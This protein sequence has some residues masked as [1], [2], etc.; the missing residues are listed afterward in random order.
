MFKPQPKID[1]QN[2]KD[3]TL[4]SQLPY[5]ISRSHIHNHFGPFFRSKN[6]SSVFVT[7]NLH[8]QLIL[9]LHAAVKEELRLAVSFGV[10]VLRMSEAYDAVFRPRWQS[11]QACSLSSGIENRC[12]LKSNALSNKVPRSIDV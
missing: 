9:N 12:V 4:L 3:P 2:T 1:N 7:I 6:R 11:I 10:V 5:L 8:P